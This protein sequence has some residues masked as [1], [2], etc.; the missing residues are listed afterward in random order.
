MKNAYIRILKE[1]MYRKLSRCAVVIDAF[2]RDDPGFERGRRV[3]GD[4][5]SY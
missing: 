1:D 3:S 4:A 5:M 2:R